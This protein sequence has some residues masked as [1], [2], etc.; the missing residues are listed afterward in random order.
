MEESKYELI[1]T[2]V[3]ECTEDFKKVMDASDTPLTLSPFRDTRAQKSQ[4]T[5]L[6]EQGLFM[7][8]GEEL[9]LSRKQTQVTDDTKILHFEPQTV[10]IN[11]P[12]GFGKIASLFKKKEN[13]DAGLRG[14]YTLYTTQL[15]QT[16][17]S[18]KPVT[19]S[20]VQYAK[21]TKTVFQKLDSQP[22]E[23]DITIKIEPFNWVVQRCLKDFKIL[24]SRL[25]VMHPGILVPPIAEELPSNSRFPQKKQ[26]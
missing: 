16:L 18:G 21:R 3:K 22:R 5:H 8:T 19:V 25:M 15:S 26:K 4:L 9:K 17:A 24:R 11:E 23:M 7:F 14:T 6:F 1:E 12:D 20:L 2:R 13:T 10:A